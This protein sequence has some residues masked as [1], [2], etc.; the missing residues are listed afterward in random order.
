MQEN[1][2]KDDYFYTMFQDI[3]RNGIIEL[4]RSRVGDNVYDLSEIFDFYTYNQ[5]S[6]EE[7]LELY[8]KGLF[9]ICSNYVSLSDY[10]IDVHANN[11]LEFVDLIL[12]TIHENPYKESFLMSL[13]FI[14]R[15]Y[16]ETLGKG[17]PILMSYETEKE[18]SY[19]KI[20]LNSQYKLNQFESVN[21]DILQEDKIITNILKLELNNQIG[22]INKVKYIIRK[23][24]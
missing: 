12:E 5:I 2:V 11:S 17:F 22:P 15:D 19:F 9:E 16:L 21:M 10:L 14:Y 7:K 6:K 8:N 4:E 3:V 13:E 24:I 18:D 23:D 20:T 1:K